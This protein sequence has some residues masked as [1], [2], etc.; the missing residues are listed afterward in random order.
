MFRPIRYFKQI[1][2]ITGTVFLINSQLFGQAT[3]IDESLEPYINKIAPDLLLQLSNKYDQTLQ[4]FIVSISDSL[5]FFSNLDLS[6]AEVSYLYHPTQTLKVRTSSDYLIRNLLPLKCINFVRKVGRIPLEERN[7]SGHDIRLNQIHL[8][9]R[10]F[11]QIN[12]RSQA[13]SIKEQ[14]FDPSDIDFAGRILESPSAA[15]SIS[16]HATDMA[17]IIAGGGS[18][19]PTALGAAWAASIN[20]SDFA[21]LLPDE[22][23]FYDQL[24]ITVQNHSYGVGIENFY[25]ADA[26]AFDKS[27]EIKPELLH[28]FSAGNQGMETSELG[29]YS[30]IPGYAN[31]TGSFK[32][33]KNVLLVGAQTSLGDLSSQSSHGPAYDGRI[34]PDLVAYGQDGSSGAAA[35]VSGLALLLQQAYREQHADTLPS[36]SLLRAILINTAK[37]MGHEGP[38]FLAGHGSLQAMHAVEDLINQQF[39]EE[40]ILEGETAGFFIEVPAGQEELSFTLTWDDPPS[41]PMAAQALIHDIDLLVKTP[42]A[43]EIQPWVLRTDAQIDSL[44]LPAVRGRDS[45][46]NVEKIS[47]K[48]PIPG[49]YEVL[50]KGTKIDG[51]R[52]NFAVAYG[53]KLAD[54]IM[55]TYPLV[56]SKLEANSSQ[57]IRWGLPENLRSSN[58]KLDY[59]LDQGQTWIE[60]SDDIALGSEAFEW[61]T[62]DTFAQVQ[63]RLHIENERLVSNMFTIAPVPQVRFGF[64]CEDSLAL[65]WSPVEG[66]DSY[67]VFGLDQYFDPFTEIIDTFTVVPTGIVG[68]STFA[69]SPLNENS[70][71]LR[72]LAAVAEEQGATCY[73][74]NFSLLPLED[75]SVLLGLDAGT[76]YQIEKVAFDQLELGVIKPLIELPVNREA[77]WSFE[78]ANLNPGIQQFRARIGFANGEEISSEFEPILIVR[79]ENPLVFPNPISEGES[80]QL[81]IELGFEE[82][83]FLLLDRNAR[84]VFSQIVDDF[85]LS[86]PFDKIQPGVYFYLIQEGDQTL[87]KGK[88]IIMP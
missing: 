72:S 35:L 28:V 74:Q 7:L 85:E 26:Q 21:D 87:D 41:N 13:V 5:E 10:A 44:S 81:A 75:G 71:G 70:E 32:M 8:V 31:L 6:K 88:L 22:P 77:K 39:I 66:A 84:P 19:F 69:I 46:N 73:I 15:S 56:E 2:I 17:T 78:V 55:W 80:L 29:V 48:F 36:A 58:L 49:T 40:D 65:T 63:L 68:S 24:N 25:G 33:A 12:G 60:I 51:G 54:T 82:I 30:G 52:Q 1:L 4:S 23:D 38:D 47:I 16:T 64:W 67:R 45:I 53:W 79:P 59:T 18:T 86:L 14:Q 57:V 42:D 76:N 62:P 9:H 83:Q 20:S 34:K 43:K 61:I 27:V 11:P 37:D 50:V 3:N